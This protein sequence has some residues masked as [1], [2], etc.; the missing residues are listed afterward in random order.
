[1]AVWCY[2]LSPPMKEHLNTCCRSETRCL[3]TLLLSA[4]LVSAAAELEIRDAEGFGAVVEPA[5]KLEQ[6]ATG[7][8]F[9]E[10]PVWVPREGGFLVFSD[11][12]ANELKKW[13]A[14]EGLKVFRTPSGNA[15]GNTLDRQ[16]RIISCEHSGRR[17]SRLEPNG[18]WVEVAA[19]FAG[20]R[21][22]SPND[23]AVKSDGTIWFTDPDY[24]L[25]T[26][27]REL[28]GC[29]VFHFDPKSG[30]LAAMVKDFDKP[31]GICFSPDE[32]RL[33][34]ADS[35]KPHHIRAFEVG[36]DNAISGG[37]VFCTIDK[38]VPDGIRCDS[39]GR[40]YSS[41]ADGVHVI[42]TDG[43]LL[44]KILVPE[45]PANLCFGGTDGR[46][47]FIT[48]RKSLYSIRLKTKGPA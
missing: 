8:Q 5:A 38:G 4:T 15:N 17:V 23:A 31:N 25:G 19:Q 11:I 3:I 44:G 16:N 29:Y 7:M 27:S 14:G 36:G 22:N 37:K 10:G 35:G 21:F 41:A 28:E 46:T 2:L 20:K 42:A 39:E 12:P 1:M 33:Y 34:I 26:G 24:G 13:V 18:G 32:K 47:L 43:R 6:L 9:T 30:S 45:T 40:L 48:A